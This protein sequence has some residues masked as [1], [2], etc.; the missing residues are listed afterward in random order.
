MMKKRIS[1]KLSLGFIALL[2]LGMGYLALI[3]YTGTSTPFLLVRGTSMEPALHAGDLLIVKDRPAAEIQEGDVVVFRVPADVRERLKMPAN[4]VHR[5]LGVASENS[6]LAFVTKG[7]NSDVDP[8]NV[9][10]SA[11]RGVVVKNLGP[12]GRPILFLTDRS[13]LLFLGLPL[14]T[15]VFI[16]LAVLGLGPNEKGEIPAPA[17]GGLGRRFFKDFGRPLDR[18]TSA[19]S[20]YGVHLQSHTSI[21]KRMAG[22]SSGLQDAVLQQNEILVELAEVVR[23]LKYAQG[24]DDEQP[25]AQQQGASAELKQA[26]QRQNEVLANLA[27][28]VM[29]LNGKTN[30]SG[31]PR[32]AQAS[33]NGGNGRLRKAQ[34]SSN[35]G[36]GRTR[37]AQASSNGGNGVRRKNGH[38]A[39]AESRTNINNDR[40]AAGFK[41]P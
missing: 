24:Q 39:S 15:F 4:A 37:K 38:A 7:D 32:K 19:V 23:D 26:V 16:V 36:N 14:L 17:T 9:P 41:I 29:D 20:K 18:L 1:G 2:L 6:E 30:G 3:S 8:F 5:I 31:R 12:W 27:A 21:V 35:G 22:T 13:V 10:V 40:P 33:S 34:A 25:A 11:V 28:V